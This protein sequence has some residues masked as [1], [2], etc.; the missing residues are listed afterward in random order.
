MVVREGTLSSDY[1][2][3]AA[4]TN[5]VATTIYE[6]KLRGNPDA[7][8]INSE[9]IKARLLEVHPHIFSRSKQSEKRYFYYTLVVHLN[10]PH[11]LCPF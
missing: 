1:F 4:E 6:D 2:S 3:D 8:D 9:D 10:V 11:R 5:W 7:Y